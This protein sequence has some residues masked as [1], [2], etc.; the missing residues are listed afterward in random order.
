[1]DLEEEISEQVTG[2]ADIGLFNRRNSVLSL[3][4]RTASKILF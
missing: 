2:G 4:E 1:M 3:I